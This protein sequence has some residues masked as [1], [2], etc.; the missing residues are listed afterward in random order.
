MNRL[1]ATL[2]VLSAVACS[3]ANA[4]GGAAPEAAPTPETPITSKFPD[5]IDRF[6]KGRD[7]ADN[8]RFAEATTEFNQALKI[9]PDFALALAYRGTVTPGPRGQTDIEQASA[10]AA[11][12]A[13]GN[14]KTKT[15]A[16]PLPKAEQLFIEASLAGRRGELAKAEGLW[17]QVTEAAPQDW[18]AQMALAQ[19][20]LAEE[21]FGEAIDALNK[22]AAINSNAGP[23][24]N[25]LGYAHLA[26]GDTA[27]AVEALKRY[28]SMNPNEPNPHDSLG[29]ALMAAGDLVQAE[30]E[31]KKAVEISPKFHIAW[32]GVAYT[33]FFRGD[34]SGG[35]EALNQARDAAARPADRAQIVLLWSLAMLG[36][37]DTAGGLKQIN[38]LVTSPEATTVDM[39][40]VPVYRAMAAVEASKKSDAIADSD[41]AMAS[42]TGGKL[43]A[44]ASA[45]LR[46]WALTIRVAA[47]GLTNDAAGA[48]KTVAALQKEAAARPDDPSLQSAVH[49]GLGMLAVA[50][51]DVKAARGH[52]DKCGRLESY[53]HW[54]S[55][56]ASRKAGDRAG[57]D[58]SRARLEKMYLRDPIYLY[59][60][61]SVDR[62]APRPKQSN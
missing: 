22:A 45:A 28:A 37:G 3:T 15:K 1:L 25:S 9:D 32:Q 62:T 4:P 57:A 27:A 11:T 55:F 58:A 8:A 12:M 50:Q 19:Q 20:L 38:T 40:F 33:K 24:F 6:K 36:K 10:K 31:F 47:E 23:V 42:G 60:R 56:V 59:A 26:Q 44:A 18:R 51:K 7:L 39:A 61:S 41:K 29:E 30:A 35:R 53:C 13:T 52:F 2:A 21:K 34:L 14:P 16:T 54:Q 46:R 5:A 48:E 17:K 43:P 49:F